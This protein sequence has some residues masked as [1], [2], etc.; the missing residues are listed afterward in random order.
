M[1][2]QATLPRAAPAPRTDVKRPRPWNV[3]LLDDQDHTYE[4]VIEMM[5]KVFGHTAARALAIAKTVDAHGRAVCLTTHRE[6]GE[7]KVQQVH[8]FGAD[9]HIASCAGPMSAILEPAQ[10]DDEDASDDRG[11]PARP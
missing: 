6:L 4:Y 9:R 3:V 7:L 5:Q 1:D 10:G 11:G 2:T 8:G